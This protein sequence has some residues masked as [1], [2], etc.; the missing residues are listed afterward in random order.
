MIDHIIVFHRADVD[1]GEKWTFEI[2]F[3]KSTP[4][5][6]EARVHVFQ[7]CGTNSKVFWRTVGQRKE[8]KDDIRKKKKMTTKRQRELIRQRERKNSFRASLSHFSAYSISQHF[9]GFTVERKTVR[10]KVGHL[11]RSLTYEIIF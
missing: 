1:V 11:D 9:D 8:D 10:K 7:S 3:V 2:F 4:I 6:S 5:F